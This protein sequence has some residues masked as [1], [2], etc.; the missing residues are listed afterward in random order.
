MKGLELSEKFY[1]E[2]GKKMIDDNFSHII[3]FTAYPF[4]KPII[5]V[6]FHAIGGLWSHLQG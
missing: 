6:G 3:S 5:T 1:N 2:Y 4:G